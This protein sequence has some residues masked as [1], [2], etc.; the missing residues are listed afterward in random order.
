MT[1]VKNIYD[2]INSFAPFDTQE[3]WDNSGFL[4]GDSK[5]EV[6]K[7]VVTLDVNRDVLKTAV[8]QKIDLIVSHHPVIFS[9]LN[10]IHTNSVVFD[11]IQND[12]SIISA[13]T[14]F[15]IADGGISESLAKQLGLTAIE[16]SEHCN[17]R[18][19][20]LPN[21]MNVQELAK[22]VKEKLDCNSVRYSLSSKKISKVAVCGGAG[23]DFTKEAMELADAFVTGDASY[24]NILDASEDNYCLISAGHFNTEIYGTKAL[25]ERLENLFID[26]EFLFSNQKNPIEVV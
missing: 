22:Y 2:Y 15:D 3:S 1:T 23:A 24:H 14:N 4:V 12:I 26:V 13:H 6:K 10:E 17:L 21:E 19:G 16:K 5:K 8:S 11:A 25:K 7:C 20:Q 18:I 9:K